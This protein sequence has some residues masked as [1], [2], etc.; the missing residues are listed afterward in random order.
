LTFTPGS[1][2]TLVSG[3]GTNEV[4]VE[5][6]IV[7][8]R[9]FVNSNGSANL[10][11]S[12]NADFNGVD[13]LTMSVNDQGDLPIVGNAKTSTDRTVLISVDPV[14]D[15]P[16]VTADTDSVDVVEIDGRNNVRGGPQFLSD[17]TFTVTDPDSTFFNRIVVSIVDSGS[18]DP[19]DDDTLRVRPADHQGEL[20]AKLNAATITGNNTSN[21]LFIAAGPGELF[22]A[23]D[24]EAILQELRLGIAENSPEGPATRDLVI[25]VGDA[26]DNAGNFPAISRNLTLEVNVT[27]VNDTPAW[28]RENRFPDARATTD[29]DT[30]LTDVFEQVRGNHQNDSSTT[31]NQ[32]RLTDRDD[33]TREPNGTPEQLT[34]RVE[35]GTLTFTEG[36]GVTLVSGNGTNEVVVEGRIGVLNRFVNGLGNA[37]LDYAPNQDFNGTD[38]LTM[39]VTDQGDLPIVGNVK[40]STERTVEITVDPVN[41]APVVVS[42]TEGVEFTEIDGSNNPGNLGGPQFLTGVDFTVTDVDSSTFSVITISITDTNG[43]AVDDDTLRV[44]PQDHGGTGTA[45]RDKLDNATITGNNSSNVITVT[46]GPGESFTAAEV[47]AILEELRLRIAEDSPAGPAIRD[48]TITVADTGDG[49]GNEPATSEPLVLQVDVSGVNDTPAWERQNRFPDAQAFTDEDTPLTDV[50]QSARDYHTANTSNLSQ[51]QLQDRDDDTNVTGGTPEQ[52][53]LRVENGVLNFTDGS[54]VTLVSGNGT[55]EVVVEGSITALRNFVNAN[56]SANL[57]YSPNTDFNGVDTLTM[58]VTDQGDLPIVGNVKTSTDRTVLINVGP[59]ND[60]PVIVADTEGVEFTEIDGS[61]NPGNLGGPQF[62]TGVDFTITDVDSTAFTVITISITNTIGNAVDG[63]TLR[64]RPQDH[65]STGTALRDKLD[66]ATITGSNS[67]NVITVTAG[68]GETFTAEEVEAILQELRLRIAEDTPAGPAP[69]DLSITVADNG[70]GQGNEPATSE[71]LVLQVDVSGVNDTPAWERQDRFPDAQAFTDEDTPLTDVFQSARDYHTANTSNLSQ[72]QLQDRDD[73]TNVTGGTPEQLTLRVENGVLNFTDGGGVTL[74]SGNGTN[75]VVVEGSISALRNFVNANGSANLTYSPN[76]NFNGVDT[77]TMSVTDQGDLPIEGNV[78]TSTDRTVLINVDPV[79]DAPVNSM[80]EPQI[81]NEDSTLLLS[82]LNGNGISVADIDA[83]NG[84]LTT[85]V[86]VTTGALDLSEGGGATIAGNGGSIVTVTGTLDEINAALASI[87]YTPPADFNGAVTLT[88]ETSDGGNTG[89]GGPLTDTDTVAI[90]VNPVNDQPVNTMPSAQ[91]TPDDTP[92]VFSPSSGN[93][94]FVSDIDAGNGVMTTTVTVTSGSLSA[95]SGGGA[96][97]G[98]N[99]TATV[100]ISG[101][102]A[103]INAALAGLTFTPVDV[104][105]SSATVVL[106]MTTNDNG[107]TGIGGPLSATNQIS[108]TVDGAL[109]SPGPDDGPDPIQNPDDTPPSETD[110]L[111][112]GDPLDVG[113]L[114]AGPAL[115]DDLGPFGGGTPVDP[116]I[117]AGIGGEPPVFGNPFDPDNLPGNIDL[118]RESDTGRFDND[119]I[120]RDNTPALTG[121]APADTRVVITSSIGGVIGTAETDENGVWRLQAPEMA[122]GAHELIATP[123]DEEG[124]EGTAS[125]PLLVIIDT[126]APETPPA[127]ALDGEIDQLKANEQVPLNGTSEPGARIVV[128][129]DKDGVVGEVVADEN[130]NWSL[131]IAPLTEG[132]H[133]L[134]VTATDVAGNSSAASP[135]LSLTVLPEDDAASLGTD[136]SQDL[137]SLLSGFTGSGGAALP[138]NVEIVSNPG[139]VGFTRQVQLAGL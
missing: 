124:S 103:Q 95:S 113:Q 76:A 27:G 45:L 70:D 105:S 18:G 7:A 1:G 78:R 46:A 28:E 92:L 100:V 117:T 106:S 108:I 54:G 26:G 21:T 89:K 39:T 85:I 128:T 126:Q 50:F 6:S 86:S 82:V 109:V 116:I 32:F 65:G 66:N 120:T 56:G 67:S 136:G 24:V 102:S 97:I 79:N 81:M 52:L 35:N 91:T 44:R 138:A 112:D 17:V 119:D 29:E 114:P 8:L 137:A 131:V 110:G 53:T 57:T 96:A 25:S 104:G 69:R 125:V 23:A 10:A 60:A 14:N 33:D 4:V 132:N 135:A 36:S 133:A 90:T 88:V 3:N 12:P 134:Q 123:I 118:V 75:E 62:L 130:G 101:T 77:L 20:R 115:F 55:N 122:D 80:P 61:N 48:L 40:T 41:D 63:D 9:N 42:D 34:L 11:Y 121:S 49:L 19:V 51:F 72:F 107:N 59:V 127:P 93:G 129:S 111:F 22:T 58:S 68:P 30:P 64:V 87:T 71:P 139:A 73:D 38:T 15:R 31:T 99:G 74:V 84:D 47:E 2:V 5:G 16:V 43:N 98:G 13:T 37:N 94:L 83:G